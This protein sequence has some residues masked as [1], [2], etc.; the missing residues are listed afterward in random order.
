MGSI[1][2]DDDADSLPDDALGLEGQVD[3]GDAGCDPAPAPAAGSRKPVKVAKTSHALELKDDEEEDG[4]DADFEGAA[5]EDANQ[6]ISFLET[7]VGTASSAAKSIEFPAEFRLRPVFVALEQEGLTKVPPL[8]GCGVFLHRAS[9]Q[10]HCRYGHASE[11]NCAPSWN[12]SLRSERKALLIA[13]TKMW[14]WY[15]LESKRQ[16]DRDHL[17]KLEDAL[18]ETSF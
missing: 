5:T 1:W 17:A 8:K 6:F 11:L 3:P 12:E 9:S 14:K 7:G 13:L 2:G 15:S 4:D 18:K 10:W 16:Q